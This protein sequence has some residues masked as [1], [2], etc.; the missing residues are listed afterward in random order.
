[1]AIALDHLIVPS[2][3]R[4]ASARSLAGFLGVPWAAEQGS[5]TPVYV[6]ESL[7]LDFASRDQFESHHYCFR[8]SDAEFDAIFDRL[9]AAGIPY[10]SHPRGENDMQ[11]NTRLGGKNLYWQDADG[12]L[13]EILTVSYARADSPALATT[14]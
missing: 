8:V 9:R 13:W 5:F 3:D 7:T 2:R 1:M 4:L 6:T 14:G 12:H 11:I 10:R